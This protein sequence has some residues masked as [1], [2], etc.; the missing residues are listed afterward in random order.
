MGVVGSKDTH[1]DC[2]IVGFGLAGSIFAWNWV[3]RLGKSAVVVD[4]ANKTNASRAAAGILNPVTGKRLVKSWLVD[5]LL[6]SAKTLYREIEAELGESF[7]YEKSIRRIYQS[8][9]ELKRWEKRTRQPAYQSFL[10]ER[11][12]PE[13]MPDPIQDP[14][15]SFQIRNVGNLDTELFLDV[16]LNWAKD[17]TVFVDEPFKHADLE[18]KTD[19]VKWKGWTADRVVFCEGYKIADNPWFSWL[20]FSPAKGEILTLSGV[21]L[22]TSDILSKQKW[23]LPKDDGTFIA[24]STWSWDKL[25]ETATHQGK[26]GLLQGLKQMLGDTSKLKVH[27]HRA[28][29]RPCTDDRKPYVGPHPELSHLHVF[30]GFGSKGSLMVPLL[31]E[32]Y[33]QAI[34][35]G[36]ELNNEANLKR[37][38]DRYLSE[39][40]LPKS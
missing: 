23:V 28:G 15:G 13:Q 38:I 12:A 37:V 7:F 31:A 25:D 34:L 11:F 2:L 35:K 21:E 27:H 5:D 17:A 24:G 6:P 20:P 40:H 9:E 1:K 29:V 39:S 30:N 18:V 8:E 32:D 10:G 14:L 3:K 19:G 36:T 16:M 26:T 33:S 22:N 4:T